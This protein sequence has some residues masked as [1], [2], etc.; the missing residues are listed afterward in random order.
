M[1][2]NQHQGQ[3][4][5]T[6]SRHPAPSGLDAQTLTHTHIWRASPPSCHGF[7][8]LCRKWIST[9]KLVKF[10]DLTY[11][12]AARHGPKSFTNINPFNL[13][14]SMVGPLIIPLYSWGAEAQRSWIKCG[15][16]SSKARSEMWAQA[17]C[18]AWHQHR[19]PESWSS[20]QVISSSRALIKYI[21]KTQHGHAQT[22]FERTTWT[23]GLDWLTLFICLCVFN[24]GTLSFWV[25][26]I[27]INNIVS[28]GTL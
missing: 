7:A 4:L 26:E 23:T 27:H 25:P 8:K 22:F 6:P 21:N 2:L 24:Q 19:L 3:L 13:H 28:E 20:S 5:T 12:Y 9:T 15:Y 10:T 17:G 18:P 1:C 16:T 11:T 14:N